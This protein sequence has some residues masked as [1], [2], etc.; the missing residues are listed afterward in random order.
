M[1]F[2]EVIP[3]GFA[4]LTRRNPEIL[5]DGEKELAY[6]YHP[7][8]ARLFERFHQLQDDIKFID[9]QI[10]FY[11]KEN[12]SYSRLTAMEGVGPISGI[13]LFATPGT[14]EAFKNRREFSAYIGLIPKQ[15][16]SGSK[17]NIIGISKCVANRRLRAVLIRGLGPY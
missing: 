12:N 11:V 13:L 5:E 17:A 14:G 2:S 10:K 6:I 4:A 16:S 9:E 3:Q 15:Y 1:E 7:T 8:L